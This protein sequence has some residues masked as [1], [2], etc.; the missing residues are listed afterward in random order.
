MNQNTTKALF[1][2]V[3]V[4]EGSEPLSAQVITLEEELAN[5][6]DYLLRK[7]LEKTRQ[8]L[9]G[10]KEQER[11]ALIAQSIVEATDPSRTNGART[12]GRCF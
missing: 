8:L 10:L 6:V 11:I 5:S 4:P 7:I 3:R 12:T 1:V 9:G 2:N